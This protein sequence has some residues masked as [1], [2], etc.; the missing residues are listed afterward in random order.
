MKSGTLMGGITAVILAA[1]CAYAGGREGHGESGPEW[2]HSR[3]G[4]AGGPGGGGS[5][6]E[7]LLIQ[8]LQNRELA[9]EV[10]LNDDQVEKLKDR[11]Y[12]LRK[13][14]IRLRAEQELAGLEQA[15]RMAGENVDEDAVMEAVEEKYEITKEMAKLKVKEILAVKQNLTEEQIGK[16]RKVMRERMRER[17]KQRKESMKRDREGK[18]D[19]GRR[20]D[21][22]RG[23]KHAGEDEKEIYED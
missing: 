5:M 11:M 4:K 3:R 19:R 2:G 14:R 12:E 13:E 6:H 22:R 1:A 18:H 21:V 9:E 10:G 20:G 17:M 23:G 16:I 8:V 7:M 15:R